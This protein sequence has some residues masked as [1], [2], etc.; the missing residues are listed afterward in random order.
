MRVD[1]EYTEL[2][3]Q[4][5]VDL[6]YTANTLKWYSPSMTNV[7]RT[8]SHFS[9]GQTGFGNFNTGF[10]TGNTPDNDPRLG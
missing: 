10:D 9:T 4:L 8:P 5:L 6:E 3:H 1:L 7:V 2:V